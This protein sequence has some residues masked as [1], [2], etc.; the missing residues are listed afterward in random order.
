MPL[1]GYD[2]LSDGVWTRRTP[3]TDPAMAFGAF[4][5]L[6][7]VQRWRLAVSYPYDGLSDGV[8]DFRT[9]TT[10]S[11]M[12]FGGFVPLQR[13]Q[14]VGFKSIIYKFNN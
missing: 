2:G 14:N 5:P 1:K 3:T 10:G 7:R 9:P 4:V 6:R 11:A 8:W 12:A 13:V